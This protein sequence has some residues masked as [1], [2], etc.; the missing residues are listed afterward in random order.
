MRP[1][2]ISILSIFLLVIGALVILA[3]IILAL[4]SAIIAT[5]P[6]AVEEVARN[7]SFLPGIP[8]GLHRTV[9]PELALAFI[10]GFTVLMG[11]V[12]IVIGRGLW[13]GANWARWIAIIFFGWN[14][15]TSLLNLLQGQIGSIVSLAINGLIVYY[16]FSPHVR[17]FFKASI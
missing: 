17:R 13:T 4:F 8:L 10:G 15:L 14:S 5:T 16:L 11:V 2:G 1:V 12:M 9:A 6:R 3:G 7:F